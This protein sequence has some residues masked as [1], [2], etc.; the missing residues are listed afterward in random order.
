MAVR[1]W[2]RGAST[3]SWTAT[4]PKTNWGTASN[5]QNNAS[6]PGVNDD[7]IFDGVGSGASNC[8]MNTQPSVKSLT[9]TGYSNTLSTVGAPIY[10]SGACVLAGT[11]SNLS[12]Y[13]NGTG[14]A[15]LDTGGNTLFGIKV[16]SGTLTLGSNVTC[17]SVFSNGSTFNTGNY[18]ITASSFISDASTTISLGSSTISLT[19][20]STDGKVV[21]QVY[22]GATVTAGT[23]T[24]YLTGVMS[25]TDNRLFYGGGYTYN[26]LK[27]NASD[28]KTKIYDSNT[29]SS[30]EQESASGKTPYV[31]LEASKTQTVTTLTINGYDSTYRAYLQ[32]ITSATHTISCS[33]GT[34]TLNH[35]RISYSVASGGATFEARPDGVDDGNNTGWTFPSISSY[36]GGVSIGVTPG[37]SYLASHGYPYSGSLTAFLVPESA[38]HKNTEFNGSVVIE[39]TPSHSRALVLNRN[40]SLGIT[41]PVSGA[42]NVELNRSGSLPLGLSVTSLSS[43]VASGYYPWTGRQEISFSVNSTIVIRKKLKVKDP[44]VTGGCPQCG[45]LVY[46]R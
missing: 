33:S 46:N 24:I 43:R 12:V 44:V 23:S 19:G 2:V 4:S 31:L 26:N 37:S 7:V 5:T 18:N 38:S 25:S 17:S 41:F 11:V 14:T 34:I 28:G 27:M 39:L 10:I 16:L 22:S 36:S 35:V 1:Y 29:F 9:M 42:V 40:G 8:T 30:I 32:S 6:V 21:W 15:T 13:F 20:F 45:C 3:D